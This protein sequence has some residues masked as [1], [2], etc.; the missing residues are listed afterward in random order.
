M[1]MT[2]DDVAFHRVARLD[3]IEITKSLGS[4]LALIAPADASAID[5]I[6]IAAYSRIPLIVVT[7]D[8]KHPP[9]RESEYEYLVVPGSP[10]GIVCGVVEPINLRTRL[11]A[12]YSAR[13]PGLLDTLRSYAADSDQAKGNWRHAWLNHDVPVLQ[14]CE[15]DGGHLTTLPCRYHSSVVTSVW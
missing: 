1:H 7:T 6:A 9:R 14:W 5:S 12:H 11:H 4:R 3:V 13:S 15:K 2:I 8:P 10:G